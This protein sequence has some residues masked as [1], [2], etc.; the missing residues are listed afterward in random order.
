M[1]G[2]RTQHRRRQEQQ[3]AHKKNRA[4]QHESKCDVSVRSVPTVNGVAF[5]TAKLPA[6]AIGA[7]IG[8]NRPNNMTRP[9]AISQARCGA[10]VGASSAAKPTVSPK[11]FETGAVVGRGRSEFVNDFRKTVCRWIV[12]ACQSPNRLRRIDRRGSESTSDARAWPATPVSFPSL[13]LFCPGIPACGRPS[14]RR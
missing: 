2:H 6:I 4:Q 1:F 10:L 12:L 9:Q 11:S 8:I 7:M 13:Q 5:L 14:G 3:S